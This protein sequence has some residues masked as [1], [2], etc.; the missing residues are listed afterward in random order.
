MLTKGSS[1]QL[2]Q[3]IAVAIKLV[4]FF[5]LEN[6]LLDAGSVNGHV[7][8]LYFLPFRLVSLHS[9]FCWL[10]SSV[11]VAVKTVRPCSCTRVMF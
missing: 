5:F 2:F 7:Q 6:N 4:S 1:N 8:L 9:V 11:D 10:E 3:L